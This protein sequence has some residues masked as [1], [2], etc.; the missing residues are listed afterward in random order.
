MT[1]DK[2]DKQNSKT[3]GFSDRRLESLSSRPF[4]EK[5]F[6]PWM[7]WE[8]ER[9]GFGLGFR[10]AGLL[11]VFFP[12]PLKSDHYA[13]PI[14]SVR[15]NEVMNEWGLYLTWSAR[16]ASLMRERGLNAICVKHPWRYLGLGRI[17]RKGSGTLVFLPHS[18]DSLK[19]EFRWE[20]IRGQL[21]S[22]DE[23]HYPLTV[24]IGEQDIKN[25]LH[26]IVRLE[27]KLPIVTAGDL[28]SQIFPFRFWKLLARYRYTVGFN[29][30]SHTMYCIWAGRPFRIMGD[31]AFKYSAVDGSGKISSLSESTKT[32]I[33]VDNPDKDTQNIM[34]LFYESL[35]E[36]SDAPSDFQ[37]QVVEQFTN[38]M[39]AVSR[40]QLAI[41]LW[42]Q[43]WHK[44]RHLILRSIREVL[45]LFSKKT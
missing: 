37:H 6:A 1:V 16:K 44:R 9:T 32:R 33:A 14:T 12:L 4:W 43:I 5:G 40:I 34:T 29:L 23:K 45:F 8:S 13:D 42:S 26:H 41:I 3:T 19:S 27:L 10:V 22:L 38:S 21:E 36:D 25:N 31:G 2:K 20:S 7:A 39:D 24:C 30:A 17:K 15:E 11:P 18:H 28:N 35:L